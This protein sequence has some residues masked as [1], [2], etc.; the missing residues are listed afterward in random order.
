MTGESNI[1][2]GQLSC[3]SCSF[4]PLGWMPCEGQVLD[5]LRHQCL[6]SLLLG[7]FGGD[8]INTFALPDLRGKEP[9]PGLKWFIAE[10]GDYPLE[11]GESGR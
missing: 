5:A 2:V 6:F 11:K 9:G 7:R 3:L 8:G 4:V 1:L 10:S